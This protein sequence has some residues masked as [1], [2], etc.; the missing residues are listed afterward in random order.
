MNCL[1]GCLYFIVVL[2][3]IGLI[4]ILLESPFFWAFLLLIVLV[5]M[6]SNSNNPP[7]SKIT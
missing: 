1:D 6:I 3:L 5:A 7:N 2:F 4:G